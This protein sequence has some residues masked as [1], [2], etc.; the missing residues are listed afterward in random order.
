MLLFLLSSDLNHFLPKSLLSDQ[1]QWLLVLLMLN[2][3]I[4]WWKR[5]LG[6][7]VL[8]MQNSGSVTFF[9]T[10]RATSV[11]GA[12]FPKVPK[13]LGSFRVSQFPL[14]LKNGEDLS[15]Q[16][17]QSFCFL[18]LWRPENFSGL[19]RNGSLVRARVKLQHGSSSVLKFTL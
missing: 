9:T 10:A 13:I 15:R 11:L 16:T 3:I 17:S 5:K 14:Y 2:V 19:S 12:R 8:Q 7:I 4:V 6:Y 1:F 18:L